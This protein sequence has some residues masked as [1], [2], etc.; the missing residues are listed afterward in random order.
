MNLP[1]RSALYL[2]SLAASAAS[3]AA[4]DLILGVNGQTRHQVLVPDS[5]PDER[6]GVSGDGPWFVMDPADELI[7]VYERRS[8]GRV[9]PAVVLAA[10]SDR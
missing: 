9:K 10:A 5:M 2:L 8:E 7:A 6:L 3:L 4:G 1:L